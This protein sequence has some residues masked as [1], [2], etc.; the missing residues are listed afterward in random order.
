MRVVVIGAGMAGILSAIKL[1]EAGSTTSPSTRRP[2][3]SAAPGGRTPTRASP[4]TC[5]SHLYS[6]S[7]APNPDWSHG[8]LARAR[9]SS[10]YFE[11]VAARHGVDRTH[12]LRR[13]GRALEL[14][15]VALAPRARRAGTPT[16]PTWS[17]PPPACSTTPATPTSTVSTTSPAPCFHSARWDH[18]VDLDGARVGVIGTGSTRG[19][20]HRRRSSTGS[21][22]LAPVPAHRAVGACR[23]PTTVTDE[24]RGD[25]PARDPSSAGRAARRLSRGVRAASPT[26][27]STPTRRSSTSSRRVPRQ[28]R[29]ARRR[30]RAAGAA[31]ARLPRG[32]QA[33]HPV[34]DFYEAI[35][36]PERPARDRGDRAGRARRACAPPTAPLHEL[37]VLVLATGFQADAFMR[38]MT[39]SGADG[40]HARR[41][42]GRAADGL[43]VDLACPDFPNLF[44]LNGPNGPVGNFSLIEVAE[45][46][47]G[48]VLQ[49]L[50][51]PRRARRRQRRAGR[52][53]DAVR[54]RARRGGAAHGLGHRLSQLVPRRPG[55]PGGL[56][57]AF[58][59]F[60]EAM[61]APVFDD[62]EVVPLG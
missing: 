21:A 55:R 39:S 1:R 47:F 49:L 62:F 4:A 18:D 12:P 48:Y 7:F 43:P 27:W 28:P 13:R 14:A 60:R 58:T 22:E 41:R 57:V 40:V 45:L 17:S 9:R 10:A 8:V 34:A 53:A 36:R 50:D 29:G 61:A 5:P 26:P 3:A 52:R 11:G 33:A 42:V 46:Q 20:D 15:T 32:V 19:P 6:Y 44:M 37:D 51:Q 30:P 25:V 38:P 31:A 59:R 54:G 24:D 2:T 23:C 16:R 35:Q 56:A